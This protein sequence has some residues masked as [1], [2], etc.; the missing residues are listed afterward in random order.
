MHPFDVAL[1]SIAAGVAGYLLGERRSEQRF[2]ALMRTLKIDPPRPGLPAARTPE[3][4]GEGGPSDGS[5]V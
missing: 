5:L 3:A 1:I 4:R 2:I